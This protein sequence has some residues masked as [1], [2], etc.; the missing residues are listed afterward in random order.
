M[1]LPASLGSFSGGGETYQRKGRA[2]E[3]QYHLLR[4]KISAIKKQIIIPGAVGLEQAM[5]QAEKPGNWYVVFLVKHYTEKITELGTWVATK[6]RVFANKWTL[7][8][9]FENVIALEDNW[10]EKIQKTSKYAPE[11]S[12]TLEETNK[13]VEY[14]KK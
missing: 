11:P 3:I 7:P 4:A 10:C 2:G 9:W 13:W 14:L 1:S 5:R 8:I 6:G 12:H